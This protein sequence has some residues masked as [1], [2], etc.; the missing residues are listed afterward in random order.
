MDVGV[1]GENDAVSEKEVGVEV[2]LEKR[3]QGQ[4]VGGEERVAGGQQ[5]GVVEKPKGETEEKRKAQEEAGKRKRP[6]T[7]RERASAAKGKQR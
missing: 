2:R 7:E 3:K 1:R 6:R 4:L 5:E